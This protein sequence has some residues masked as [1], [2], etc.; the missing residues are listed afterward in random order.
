MPTKASQGKIPLMIISP[1]SEGKKHTSRYILDLL[2]QTLNAQGIAYCMIEHQSDSL[3]QDQFQISL[4]SQLIDAF[5]LAK[6]FSKFESFDAS[7]IGIGGMSR[8]ATVANLATR[9]ELQEALTQ[10][11]TLN[12]YEFQFNCHVGISPHLLSQEENPVLTGKPT[13]YIMA[14][15]DDYTPSEPVESYVKL[16]Q[17]KGYPVTYTIVQGAQHAFYDKDI[18]T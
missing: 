16:L 6:I 12:P 1:G 10:N 7:K 11:F 2:D 18:S 5:E 3:M 9:K 17:E 4:E 15:K 8:G 13:H 14:E